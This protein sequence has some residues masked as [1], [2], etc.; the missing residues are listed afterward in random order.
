MSVLLTAVMTVTGND[1]RSGRAMTNLVRKFTTGSAAVAMRDCENYANRLHG[2]D[3][4]IKEVGGK[5]VSY[6]EMKINNDSKNI[7][8][9]VTFCYEY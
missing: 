7:T 5:R 8:E 6:R 3:A 1:Y 2:T 9:T 4:E